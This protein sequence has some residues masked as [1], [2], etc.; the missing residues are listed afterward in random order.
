MQQLNII[1][2]IREALSDGT[3]LSIHGLAKKTGLHYLTVKRYLELIE[4]MKKKCL[5]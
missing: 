5:N 4:K 1:E 3:T 2:R